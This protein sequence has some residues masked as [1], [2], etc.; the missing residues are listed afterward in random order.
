MELNGTINESLTEDIVYSLKKRNIFTVT[1]FVKKDTYELKVFTNLE[2][3]TVTKIKNDIFDLLKPYEGII[4]FDRQ[5]YKT[6]IER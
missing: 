6:G 1:D 5:I 4:G 3:E 2:I